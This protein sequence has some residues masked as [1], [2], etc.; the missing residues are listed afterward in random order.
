MNLFE[1]RNP[2]AMFS[3]KKNRAQAFNCLTCHGNKDRKKNFLNM[4][5]SSSADMLFVLPYDKLSPLRRR[6]KHIIGQAKAS[7]VPDILCTH[8]ISNE[9][10]LDMRHMHCSALLRKMVKESGVR[11]VFLVGHGAMLSFFGTQYGEDVAYAKCRGYTMPL[12]EEGI[13][14]S[15]V[16]EPSMDALLEC[17]KDYGRLELLVLKQDIMKGMAYHDREI[18]P[19]WGKAAQLCKVCD[20]DEA[21]DRM[22]RILEGE[23]LD[24]VAFDYE[25]TG[26]KPFMEGHRIVSCGLCGNPDMAFA[27]MLNERTQPILRALLA[28][29]RIPKV[30]AN[31]PFEYK[32]SHAF[33]MQ[34][35]NLVYDCCIG[36]HMLDQRAGVCGVKFQARMRYGVMEYSKAMEKYLVPSEEET[37]RYGAN[38]INTAMSAPTGT[39]LLYNAMDALLEYWIARDSMPEL[40]LV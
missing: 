25:T 39:L 19:A 29:S 13:W 15:F 20:D 7:Y 16:N 22:E 10:E 28:D 3:K 5:V 9:K 36:G 34:V 8:S 18:D 26:L 30:A 1:K 38:A 27:F 4:S 14:L 31:N 2:L 12:L 35:N 21:I 37:G 32:W 24:F 33:G 17:R 23:Y 6:I 11:H 40:G